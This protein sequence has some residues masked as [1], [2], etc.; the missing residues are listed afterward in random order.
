VS[1]I[2]GEGAASTSKSERESAIEEG[3]IDESD[4]QQSGPSMKLLNSGI[5]C[6]SFQFLKD[7][8]V[9]IADDEEEQRIPVISWH[10]WGSVVS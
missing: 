8:V 7:H 6:A 5:G 9:V 4:T 10:W 3:Q 1:L 2:I